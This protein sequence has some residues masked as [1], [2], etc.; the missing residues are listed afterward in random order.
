M[1]ESFETIVDYIHLKLQRIE[2]EL[3]QSNSL[4]YHQS[5]FHIKVLI[6]DL[7]TTID[8][9]LAMPIFDN[10]NHLCKDEVLSNLCVIYDS[11]HRL[12]DTYY[13]NIGWIVS[14]GESSETIYELMSDITFEILLF[15]QVHHED[16]VEEWNKL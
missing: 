16:Y 10:L 3:N 7:T 15:L 4:H 11:F 9:F 13:N 8:R 14:K 2:R 6:V 5:P 12:N 1:S